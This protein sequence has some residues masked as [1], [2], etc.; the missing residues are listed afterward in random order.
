MDIRLCLAIC[1]FYRGYLFFPVFFSK[2]YSDLSSHLDSLDIVFMD[3]VQSIHN[4]HLFRVRVFCANFSWKYS[5]I[6][7]M[8]FGECIDV[9]YYEWK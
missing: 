1:S 5:C 2:G 7:C 4:H 6:E 9:S 8:V 3:V